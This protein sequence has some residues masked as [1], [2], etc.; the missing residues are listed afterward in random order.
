MPVSRPKAGPSLLQDHA[1][2]KRVHEIAKEQESLASKALLER[3]QAAG[4]EVK[5]ASSSVEESLALRALG[6]DGASAA[7]A[8]VATAV[9]EPPVAKPPAPA[10]VE[11]PASTPPPAATP[12]PTSAPTR[13]PPPASATSTTPAAQVATLLLAVRPRAAAPTAAVS[14]PAPQASIATSAPP[15]AP[16][17]L[18]RP[19]DPPSRR[20]TRPPHPPRGWCRAPEHSRPR[21]RA[22]RPSGCDP[23]ATRAQA[24]VLPRAPLSRGAAAW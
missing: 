23:R 21:R 14:D 9:A 10:V 15:P 24:S 7:V 4:V 11:R 22:P 6:G 1:S 12:S 20:P 17:A 16:D 3:L 18:L 5:T 2:K 19:H 8:P 13:V